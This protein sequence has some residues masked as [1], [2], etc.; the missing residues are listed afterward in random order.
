MW[1]SGDQRLGFG[2][3]IGVWV[4]CGDRRW[5]VDLPW[6]LFGFAVGCMGSDRCGFGCGVEIGVRLWVCRGLCG[7]DQCG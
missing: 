4:W 6:V 2:T 1:W 5:A 3:E 7:S